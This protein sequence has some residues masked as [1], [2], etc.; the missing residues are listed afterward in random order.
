MASIGGE[1]VR[2]MALAWLAG[3]LLCVACGPRPATTTP[4]TPS[5]TPPAVPAT[6]VPSI[7]I[8]APSPIIVSS[9]EPTRTPSLSPAL[10]TASGTTTRATTQGTDGPQHCQTADLQLATGDQVSEPTGQH[11]LSLRLVSHAASACVL[12]GYPAVAILNA[13][14]VA[15]PFAVSHS[16]D[17]VVTNAA[18]QAVTLGPGAT[19]YVTI[20]KYRCDSGDLELAARVQLTPPGSASS[21]TLTLPAQGAVFGYCGPG[22]P[23]STVAVSPVEPTMRDTL[24]FPRL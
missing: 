13:S 17:Q 1:P 14:G 11:S 12:L 3:L 4:T 5:F 19:A 10:S 20:N 16:G 18:P 6:P 7:P 23:G 9:P 15:L 24:T 8:A 2:V 21:L 22:D